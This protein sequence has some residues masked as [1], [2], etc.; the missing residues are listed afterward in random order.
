MIPKHFTDAG[1][2]ELMEG[3]DG[4][5]QDCSS[6]PLCTEEMSI[7]YGLQKNSKT[8]R[9][10]SPEKS[11]REWIPKRVPEPHSSKDFDHQAAEATMKKARVSVR[12]WSEAPMVSET[13]I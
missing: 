1:Q 4:I 11:F 10:E 6:S 3:K 7:A 8:E 12:A 2:R 9:E 13:G 5:N